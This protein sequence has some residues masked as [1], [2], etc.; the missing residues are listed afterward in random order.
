MLTIERIKSDN[1]PVGRLIQVA[2]W[3]T[4][5]AVSSLEGRNQDMNRAKRL[6]MQADN[7]F[8]LAQKLRDAA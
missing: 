1:I 4:R 2:E 3:N 8:S 7:L 5:E 6:R